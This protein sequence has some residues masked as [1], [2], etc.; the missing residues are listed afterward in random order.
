LN[1]F[2][3]WF[4]SVPSKC[5]LHR[6]ILDYLSNSV[7]GLYKLNAVDPWLESAWLFTP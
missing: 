3:S 1:I 4:Q 7:A 2:Q 6:Y 5:N